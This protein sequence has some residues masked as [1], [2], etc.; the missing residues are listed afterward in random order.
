[1]L[2]GNTKLCVRRAGAGFVSRKGRTAGFLPL[3]GSTFTTSWEICGAGSRPW[4]A[5]SIRQWIG[6]S[7][8]PLGGEQTAGGSLS[9]RA[10]AACCPEG[11]CDVRAHPTPHPSW[12]IHLDKCSDCRERYA[13]ALACTPRVKFAQTCAHANR[14]KAHV[15]LSLHAISSSFACAR[16]R[17]L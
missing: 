9:V 13:R 16:C 7:P 8:L 1:M 15:S 2:L 17:R 12:F 5:V 11:G 10:R 6:S 3:W 4:R 14:R